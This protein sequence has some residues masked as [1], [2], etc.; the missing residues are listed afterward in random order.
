MANSTKI[1]F[2]TIGAA[3]VLFGVGI[4]IGRTS[5]GSA[6]TVPPN[7]RASNAVNPPNVNNLSTE[8]VQHAIDQMM[9][10]FK[11]KIGGTVTVVG[12]RETGGGNA[13]AD[14]QFI[15]FTD[16]YNDWGSVPFTG[17]GQAELVHY[18]DGR[19]VLTTLIW[20]HFRRRIRGQYP[21]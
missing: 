10:E 18:T 16:N 13:I 1:L 17:T 19:T 6:Q 14:V 11:Y 7:F 5:G 21:L 8:N 20:N 12:V 15:N 9:S 4:Y 3:F 2:A